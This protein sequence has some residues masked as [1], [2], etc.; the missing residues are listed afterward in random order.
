MSENTHEEKNDIEEPKKSEISE[1]ILTKPLFIKTENRTLQDVLRRIDRKEYSLNPDFQRDFVWTKNQQSRLIESVLMRIPLPVFYV[2]RSI[3]GLIIVDGVQRLYSLQ[4]FHNNELTLKLD[5]SSPINNK[6]FKDLDRGFQI[7]FEDYNL[8]MYVIDEESDEN[9][10]FDIFD[11]VNSGTPLTSQQM[12]NSLYTGQAANCLKELAEDGLFKKRTKLGKTS[13]KKMK[14]RELINRFI[15][16]DILGYEK[17]IEYKNMDIFLAEGL[18]KIREYSPEDIE[19]LKNKFY[20][21]LKNNDEIF[22]QH[23]FRKH[24]KDS[25]AK[26]PLTMSLWEVMSTILANYKYENIKKHK[27]TIRDKFY[28]LLKNEEFKNSITLTTHS[29]EHVKT[30]FKMFKDMLEDILQ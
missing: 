16:F 7:D 27:T 24:E 28:E 30:R 15:S 3:G 6:K 22:G 18:K 19:S 9:V 12:R 13:I 25:K 5:E 20:L 17:Y 29:K 4:S 14:D 10:M 1:N 11:R 21:T 26:K 2:A 23:A 8:T